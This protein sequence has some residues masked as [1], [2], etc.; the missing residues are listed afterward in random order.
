L[1]ERNGVEMDTFIPGLIMGFREGLEAF[2]IVTIILQYLSQTNKSGFKKFV[3]NGTIAGV[4]A[5]FVIGGALFVV[6]SA[7][8]KTEEIAKIWESGASIVALV[9]VTTFI[10]WM[11]KHGSNMVVEV[12]NQVKQSLSKAGL[13]SVAFIMVVREGSEIAIF[14]FAGQYTLASI[15]LGISLALIVSLLVYK[16]MVKINLRV[17]FNITL[18]YLILQAGFLLGYAVHEGLSALKALSIISGDNFIFMKAFDLSGTVFNHKEG[19]L[20]I[21]MYVLFGWY[22]KPEWIQL[23]L[24]YGYVVGMILVWKNLRKNK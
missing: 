11:I 2:L 24:H 7:I 12:Q 14:T 8:Q 18:I 1:K 15:G 22:S 3:F 16:S 17:L 10:Y 20:G 9:F 5:S 23:I 6:S 19:V 4:L 21:P 13:F